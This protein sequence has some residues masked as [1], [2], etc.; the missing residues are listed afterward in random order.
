MRLPAP[1]RAAHP[2]VVLA[3]KHIAV[4]AAGFAVDFALLHLAMRAGL[5]PAWARVISLAC[6]VNVT[7]LLNGRFVFGCLG[8]G[9]ELLRQWLTYVVTNGFGNLCNYWIFVTLVSLHHPVVSLPSVALLVAALSAWAINFAAARLLVF[10][11]S[12]RPLGRW[13]W[14]AARRAGLSRGAPGSSRR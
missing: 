10:G 11:L 6:A 9:R 4:S 5:E 12:R 1:P 13:A 3:A 7:F 14:P 2:E 8:S